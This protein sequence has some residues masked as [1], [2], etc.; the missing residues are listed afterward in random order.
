MVL[1]RMLCFLSGDGRGGGDGDNSAC[2]GPDPGYCRDPA[3][4]AAR[5]CCFGTTGFRFR[6]GLAGQQ[7]ALNGRE[8]DLASNCGGEGNHFCLM[9]EPRFE[10]MLSQHVKDGLKSALNGIWGSRLI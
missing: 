2:A 5:S 1:L 4:R 9:L 10:I 6:M 8:K 3:P 7:N